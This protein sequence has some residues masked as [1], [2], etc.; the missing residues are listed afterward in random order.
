MYFGL[1][2]QELVRVPFI[3]LELSTSAECFNDCTMHVYST[4]EN[5]NGLPK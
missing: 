5:N 4:V 3:S 1:Q 2:E